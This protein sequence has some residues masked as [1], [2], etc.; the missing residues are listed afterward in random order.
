MWK[1]EMQAVKCL[2]GRVTISGTAVVMPEASK[3]VR[4]VCV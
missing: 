3:L 4:R 1:K 2:S